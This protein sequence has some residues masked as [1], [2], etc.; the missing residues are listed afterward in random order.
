MRQVSRYV[1]W[2]LGP[3]AAILFGIVVA[4]RI[5]KGLQR[6]ETVAVSR[7]KEAVVLLGA[8]QDTMKV[9]LDSLR[10][11]VQRVEDRQR[12]WVVITSR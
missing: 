8:N 4:T 9:D 10:V 2:I 5:E 6:V 7:T 12:A 3:L 1:L 11:A